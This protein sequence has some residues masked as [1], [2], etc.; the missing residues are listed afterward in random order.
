MGH[1]TQKIFLDGFTG[2]LEIQRGGPERAL[3]VSVSARREN[4]VLIDSW[5][6][7]RE[8]EREGETEEEQRAA[9]ERRRGQERR[10]ERKRRGQKV[11]RLT[12]DVII[13]SQS[14]Q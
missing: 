2:W 1:L 13:V 12:A 8:R 6:R 10:G 9:L 7:C 11:M 5:V 3:C 14:S 4:E